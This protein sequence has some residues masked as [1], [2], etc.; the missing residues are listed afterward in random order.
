ML[1]RVSCYRKRESRRAETTDV[2]KEIVKCLLSHIGRD[3][4]TSFTLLK[5]LEGA[6][7]E[8][9]GD[10]EVFTFGTM[11]RCGRLNPAGNCTVPLQPPIGA[12]RIRTVQTAAR[13]VKQPILKTPAAADSS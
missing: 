9:G 7:D 10:G 4:N 12:C 3:K 2:A 8:R 1:V 13:S 5:G 11:G 6:D